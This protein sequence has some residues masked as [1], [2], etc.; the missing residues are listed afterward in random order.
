MKDGGGES[1]K[2][3]M[4]NFNRLT[5]YFRRKTNRRF[6]G[7]EEDKLDSISCSAPSLRV[8]S[9]PATRINNRQLTVSVA[10]PRSPPDPLHP[11]STLP[12]PHPSPPH[13]DPSPNS[14]IHR[15]N[16]ARGDNS[17]QLKKHE[18]NIRQR[19]PQSSSPVDI[20][21]SCPAV[22]ALAT[23]SNHRRDGDAPRISSRA[24]T[25]VDDDDEYDSRECKR[26]SREME[27]LRSETRLLRSELS[28][29]RQTIAQMKEKEKQ[30]RHRLSEQARKQIER[31]S[32]KFEDLSLGENRPSQLIRRYGNLYS[33][34]RLDAMDALDELQ[35]VSEYNDLKE[36][37]LL[38]VIVLA[39][40]NARKN[41][42]EMKSHIRQILLMT[43]LNVIGTSYNQTNQRTQSPTTIQQ[44]HPAII[45]L[46][47]IIS[48]YLRKT[49]D[50]HN[51]SKNYQEVC[52]RVWATL[53]DFPNLRHCYGLQK[54]IEECVR[55]A[56]ALTIQNPP[57]AIDYKTKNFLPDS[58]T[59]FHT[60]DPDSVEVKATLWPTLREG[61]NGPCVY[62]G[63]VI[64]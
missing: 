16:S 26:C 35:E 2:E 20:A 54:Y 57:L 44:T 27:M 4:N 46:E 5:S 9:A 36:K 34:Q 11:P 61:E 10:A 19:A 52:Q 38:S 8:S 18:I 62:K 13:P 37:L 55:M 59:R 33:E 31:G 42:D 45:E 1:G 29:N 30:L 40:R 7:S 53:F 17:T 3:K 28:R 48:V 22:A 58:H 64:T 32:T 49:I 63:V 23:P 15:S 50:L 60:S 56:W 24:F 47:E 41:L 6:D 14:S 12:P 43:D 21:F 51:L 25:D 39:F